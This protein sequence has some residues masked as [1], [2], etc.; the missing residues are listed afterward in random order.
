MRIPREVNPKNVI[1][2]LK[3]KR[4]K[5]FREISKIGKEDIKTEM[6]S[7][8]TGRPKPQAILSRYRL[9]PARRSAAGESLA[10]DTGASER[11]I[12]SVKDV[13]K[14][15]IG[16]KNDPNG[17]NYVLEHEISNNRPTVRKSMERTLPKARKIFLKNFNL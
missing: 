14:L 3:I 11:L 2:N 7:T 8:K 1:G 16:F 17:D 4:S 13:D 12:A 9:S 10:R 5:A 6:R 15:K